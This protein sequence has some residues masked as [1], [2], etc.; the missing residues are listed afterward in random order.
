VVQRFVAGEPWH[1]APNSWVNALRQG[2]VA[3]GNA[4]ALLEQARM[5][6]YEPAPLM[7]SVELFDMPVA[8]MGMNSVPAG[9]GNEELLQV[10]A[11]RQLYKKV[12]LR[13]SKIIGFVGIGNDTKSGLFSELIRKQAN[14]RQI[15]D[16]L[17]SDRFT[18]ELIKDLI[19]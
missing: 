5:N 11:Q 18:S 17:L 4:A 15:K 12:I 16:A 2:T 14:V 13:D 9:E 1:D 7:E 10:D 19:A 3:G 6:V 8:A